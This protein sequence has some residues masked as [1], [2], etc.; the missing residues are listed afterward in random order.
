MLTTILEKHR[1]SFFPILG[2]PI[3][4]QNSLPLDLSRQ[5]AALMALDLSNNEKLDAYIFETMKKRGA[6]VAYGGYG[7]HR[8]F[9]GRSEGFQLETAEKARCIHL[10]I[11]LWAEVGTRIFAPLEGK[12][13]SFQY[14]A[15]YLDY[16]ATIILAHE[17]GGL[18][19]YT[20]YG[21]L[22]LAS[23]EGLTEGAIIAQGEPFAT[24]GDYD[25]NG[26][27]PSHLHCQIIEN[28]L[29]KKGDFIGVAAQSEADFYLKN[30]P[31]PA[32]F[33]GIERW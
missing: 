11:D 17:L 2:Q 8:F 24:L 12:V 5:N 13:H 15:G 28:M 14:N 19:F 27:W 23:L 10:G 6:F 32:G 3:T 31:N 20:L 9:Y 7:E 18:V 22:S 29:G 4:A 33:L 30:S 16:G 25:E 26:G 21:H 1:K